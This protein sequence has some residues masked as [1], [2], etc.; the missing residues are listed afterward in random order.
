MATR[1]H[2]F[3]EL[4]LVSGFSYTN[5]KVSHQIYTVYDDEGMCKYLAYIMCKLEQVVFVTP[6]ARVVEDEDVPE[7]V[8]EDA[9]KC[10]HLWLTYVNLAARVRIY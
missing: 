1:V 10:L 6:T 7:I 4:G 8:R 3:K 9:K 5:E 2:R